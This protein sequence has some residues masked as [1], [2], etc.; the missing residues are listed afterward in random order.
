MAPEREKHLQGV[1]FLW[2]WRRLLDF[3]FRGHKYCN[4]A[5]Y[6][7]LLGLTYILLISSQNGKANELLAQVI[8]SLTSMTEQPSYRVKENHRLMT[9]PRP[10]P[11]NASCAGT[12]PNKRN[13]RHRQIQINS[14]H[15]SPVTQDQPTAALPTYLRPSHS[16]RRR[17]ARGGSSQTRSPRAPCAP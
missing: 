4:I 5:N 10:K 7:L 15:L 16:A 17:R 11:H 8:I 1:Q 13:R 14:P 2:I 3:L 6:Q 9:L 12:N